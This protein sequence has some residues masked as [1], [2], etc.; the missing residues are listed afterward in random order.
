[1]RRAPEV[2]A[3]L[4]A[5]AL[6]AGARAEDAATRPAAR[7]PP[8]LAEL[9][10]ELPEGGR[11]ARIAVLPPENLTGKVLE[12]A[13]LAE[14]SGRVETA[15][16]RAGLEVIS[17]APVDRF[18]ARRRIRT[19]GGLDHE[20]AVAAREELDV[21]GVLA[22]TVVERGSGDPPRISVV[23]RLVSTEDDPTLYWIDG[24][25]R[26]G[27]ESPGLLQ[28][29]I[30][31]RL[32]VLERE[33][34][35]RL[36]RSLAEFLGG[37]G[38]TSKGCG[39]GRRYRPKVAYRNLTPPEDRV[40]TVAVLP[41]LN[42]T[43]RDDA[44]EVVSLEMVRQL[45]VSGRYRILEPAVVRAELLRRRLIIAGGVTL[46][47]A[48]VL[49]GGLEV[50]YVVAGTVERYGEWGS[51]PVVDFSVTVLEARTGRIAW[52]S[53]S[54]GRGSDGVLLFRWGL[55]PTASELTCRLMREV[56]DG[57]SAKA[58]RRPRGPRL[59]AP[60][61]TPSASDARI[62]ADGATKSQGMR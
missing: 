4:L 58:P 9:P 51:D 22:T 60:P 46:D 48:R 53:S 59:G 32:E 40:A 21:R 61:A 24:V 35:E 56:A 52:Q 50:D 28:L 5:A 31:H 39:G 47:T 34:L 30:V 41:F 27:E 3:T 20:A 33:A 43:G 15:L 7:E 10:P 6:S 37:S 23:L 36:A 17:G 49:L 1:M 38:P 13:E 18:L 55:V 45:A 62:H 54:R 42:R 8:H 26:A 44:G 11:A 14:L 2:I 12:R 29:G 57:I 16:A 25:S 19:T